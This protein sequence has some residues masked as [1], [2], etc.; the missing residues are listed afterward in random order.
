MSLAVPGQFAETKRSLKSRSAAASASDRLFHNIPK[1]PTNVATYLY[2]KYARRLYDL[3]V[4]YA[5][6]CR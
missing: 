4:K 3:Y 6:I 5:T 1:H 2:V